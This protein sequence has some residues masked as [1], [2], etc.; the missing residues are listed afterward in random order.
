MASATLTGGKKLERKLR[1]LQGPGLRRVMTRSIS[2]AITPLK[3]AIKKKTP[4]SKEMNAGTLKRSISKKTKSYFKQSGTIVGMVGPKTKFTEAFRTKSGKKNPALYA[5]LV[6]FGTKSHLIESPE[7]SGLFWE[8]PGARAN[9]WMED[10]FKA[11]ESNIKA[12]LS[13]ELKQGLIREAKR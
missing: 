6:L 10:E 7:G 4:V 3:T 12:T 1:N 11:Q 8:H 2:R 5:H 9:N 13:K